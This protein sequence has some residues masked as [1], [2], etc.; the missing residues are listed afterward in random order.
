[1]KNLL[2]L[3]EF[4]IV[5][6]LGKTLLSCKPGDIIDESDLIIGDIEADWRSLTNTKYLTR[7]QSQ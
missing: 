4:E 1:M 2:V 5:D 3:Q 6:G 7:R